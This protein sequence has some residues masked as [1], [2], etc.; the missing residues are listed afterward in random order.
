NNAWENVYQAS[1]T[2]VA[3]NVTNIL[4]EEWLGNAWVKFLKA[5]FTYNAANSPLIETYQTWTGTA[6][7]ND[8]RY[9][10]TYDANNNETSE[11]Y[12]EWLI[13]TWKI[14]NYHGRRWDA[15]NYSYSNVQ[16]NYNSGGGPVSYGDSSITYYKTV[17]GIKEND[18][19][20]GQL[21]VYPNPGKGVF[22]IENGIDITSIKV[23]NVQG[24]QVF[25]T[26][27]ESKIANLDLSNLPAGMYFIRVNEGSSRIIHKVII[28]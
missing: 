11:S 27:I 4:L 22:T 5:N 19:E 8:Y 1:F 9:L 2:V 10:Y 20:K 13:G 18:T 28:E 7:V 15:N 12:Q 24:T 25:E 23:H 14:N 6:W 21:L 17:V 3:N 16:R 26:K